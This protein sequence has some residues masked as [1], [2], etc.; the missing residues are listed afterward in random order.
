MFA[1]LYYCSFVPLTHGFYTSKFMNNLHY[2]HFVVCRNSFYVLKLVRADGINTTQKLS[3]M[4]SPTYPVVFVRVHIQ[5]PG[6]ISIFISANVWQLKSIK[7]CIV[8]KLHENHSQ[9]WQ[10]LTQKNS[11]NS[12]SRSFQKCR[13]DKQRSLRKYITGLKID[14]YAQ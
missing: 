12:Q 6:L 13:T 11:T 14:C 2:Q 5:V 10:K 4:L 8:V 3:K 9:K 7:T 1:M